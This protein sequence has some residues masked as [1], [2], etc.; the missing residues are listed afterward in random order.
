MSIDL[1]KSILGN[2]QKFKSEIDFESTSENP[3]FEQII[4][5][6]FI[7]IAIITATQDEFYSFSA[8]LLDLQRLEVL[9]D[10]SIYFQGYIKKK[11]DL[12]SVVMHLPSDM[13]IAAAAITTTKCITNFRPKYLFM[14]GI[15]AGIKAVTKVGDVIIA[16]K[17]LDYNEVIEIETSDKGVRTKFMNDV[18]SIPKNLKS[19]MQLFLKTFDFDEFENEILKKINRKLNY[20]FGVVV[21]GSSLVRNSEKIAQLIRDFHNLKGIDMETVGVYKAINSFDKN[22]QPD[23]LSIKSVSDY[24]DNDKDKEF[25]SPEDRRKLA[26]FSSAIVLLEFI[27]SDFF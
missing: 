23:F 1:I 12:L 21:T 16:E 7:D 17:A 20:H 11:E 14:V 3:T 22:I 13:G 27:K 10:S 9:N 24:G 8:H 19:R 25:D 26:L 18:V 4:M 15:A 5:P 6:K 2:V